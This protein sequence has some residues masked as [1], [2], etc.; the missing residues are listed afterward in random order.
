MQSTALKYNFLHRYTLTYYQTK[1]NIT[2]NQIIEQFKQNT[3]QV[4]SLI[5]KMIANL[6]TNILR[7]K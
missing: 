5:E 3:A 2:F 6:M 7:T 4:S 1:I